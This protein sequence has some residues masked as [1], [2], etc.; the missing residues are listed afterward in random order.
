[1]LRG[2]ATEAG[3][4]AERA[5]LDPVAVVERAIEE[6]PEVRACWQP[7]LERFAALAQGRGRVTLPIVPT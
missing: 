3:G 5:G 1:M 2:W 7:V 6:L 4:A